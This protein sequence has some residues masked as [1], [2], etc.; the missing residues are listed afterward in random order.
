MTAPNTSEVLRAAHAARLAV[1]EA[2]GLVNAA[3]L[4]REW[5]LSRTRLHQLINVPG[6][7]EPV[8]MLGDRP[9]WLRD[10]VNEWRKQR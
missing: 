1:Q 9:V 7:P 6:F 5:E 3:T 10:E 8:D 2:G 4:A